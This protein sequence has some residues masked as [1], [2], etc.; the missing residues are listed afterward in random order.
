M[1]CA[2]KD[3]I[4]AGTGMGCAGHGQRCARAKH[5][6][7]MGWPGRGLGCADLR[8]AGMG[9]VWIRQGLGLA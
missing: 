9:M 6:L 4:C 3:I 2:S 8:S 7:V 5:E 1:C